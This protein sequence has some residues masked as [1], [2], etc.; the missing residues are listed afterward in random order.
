MKPIKRIAAALVAL[1]AFC[2]CVALAACSDVTGLVS[3]TQSGEFPVTVNEVTINAKPS[4]VVVLSPSLA[5]V[6]LAL[7][8]DTQLAAG[9]E[10]CT[11][12]SL[13][14]LKKLSAGDAQAVVGE[15]P[16]LVLLD[17]AS[18][19][20]E[21]ALRDAGL[22]VLNLAPAKDRGDFERL[23]SQVSSALNG[24]GPGYDTGIRVAQD[25][26]QT[27]DDINRVASAQG[28]IVTVC[29][30]LYDLD[31]AAVT[32]D[33][34]ASTVMTYSGLSNA[35]GDLAGGQYAYENL[36]NANPYIIFCPP[37]LKSQMEEDSRFAGLQAVRNGRVVELDP[38]LMEWQGRTVV[39]AALEMSAAA[40]PELLEENS[41]QVT[42]P[43]EKIEDQVSS[44]IASSMLEEDPTTYEPLEEGDQG[45]DVLAMQ[46]RLDELGYLDTEYDG[47]YG[48]YTAGCVR[49][50]QKVNGLPETGT[51]D[52]DTLKM[53]YSTLAKSKDGTIA[54]HSPSPSPSGE[55]GGTP[56]PSE[57]GEQAG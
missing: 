36:R 21:Q 40:F 3:G 50:F 31:S 13:R 20:A 15:N 32:G 7:G 28:E 56:E 57:T 43:T 55:P 19:G 9:S 18:S 49:E 34:L 8:C 14:D 33:M 6:V 37:G 51:A 41:M 23:Y 26:F 24:G 22:T 27:L 42:D 12:D 44:A 45:E 16:D 46:T 53:L 1:A 54:L 48:E 29:C 30:Y 10:N 4:R 39:S 5:D 25:V 17:P 47:H 35:F 11:Q 2:L 52:N 38:S